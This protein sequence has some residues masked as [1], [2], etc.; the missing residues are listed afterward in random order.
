MP[1]LF[2]FLSVV[3]T[4]AAIIFGGLLAMGHFYEPEPQDVTKAVPGVKIRK[5]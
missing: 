5:Q 1:S 4:I 3:G 2:R